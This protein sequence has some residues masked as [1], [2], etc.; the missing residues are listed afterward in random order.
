[1]PMETGLSKK[2]NEIIKVKYIGADDP[3]S[4]R[5]GKIYHARVLKKSWFGIVD[6]TGE[7]YAY[8]PEQFHIVED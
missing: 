8:A 3:L 7:E 4:L 5:N 1:M 6:E 2:I